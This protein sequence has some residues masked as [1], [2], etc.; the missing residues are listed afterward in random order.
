MSTDSLLHI[1]MSTYTESVWHGMV[2][3]CTSYSSSSTDQGA[4]PVLI[5]HVNAPDGKFRGSYVCTYQ[6]S[7]LYY[8]QAFPIYCVLNEGK[9]QYIQPRIDH[10]FSSVTHMEFAMNVFTSWFRYSIMRY[11]RLLQSSPRLR[12][13]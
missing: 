5:S 12:D 2:P 1:T 13:F 4:S 10:H 6:F 3:Y 7:R 9:K 11:I 8:V